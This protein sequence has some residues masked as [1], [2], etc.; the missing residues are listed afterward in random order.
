MVAKILTL[1]ICYVGGPG[2]PQQAQPVVDRFLR[3]V[4]GVAGWKS[5]AAR[6]IYQATLA[7]CDAAMR[8]HQPNL[9]VVDLPAY[10]GQHRSWKL[11]PLA[12]MGKADKKRY[13][14]LVRKGSFKDLASLK[15]K[16]LVT[17][18]AADPTFLSRVVFGGKVDAA[19]HFKLSKTR[20]P[21]KGIRRVAR[22]RADATVVDELAY[23]HLKELPLKTPLEA[24]HRSGALPGLTLAVVK[25][26][27]TKALI[28]EIRRALPKLCA[29]AGAQLCRT[30]GIAAFTKANPAVFRR[31]AK[32]YSRR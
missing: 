10:L 5:N 11:E 9:V 7:S 17:P 22:G 12:H 15:G 2:T 20:R 27:T 30:F 18:L 13:F 1:L 6:G 24:I 26:R 3:Q 31:L 16:R 32:Q 28:A 23:G 4:E 14:L 25:G 29:G 19:K 21:L 8:Q